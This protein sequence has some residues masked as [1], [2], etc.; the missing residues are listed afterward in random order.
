MLILVMTMIMIMMVMIMTMM[1]DGGDDYED[2]CLMAHL[3]PIS[4][5]YKV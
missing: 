5:K 2:V 4:H 1:I 3:Y